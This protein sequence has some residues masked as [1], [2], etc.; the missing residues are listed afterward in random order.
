MATCRVEAISAIKRLQHALRLLHRRVRLGRNRGHLLA[1]RLEGA[2]VC[3]HLRRPRADPAVAEAA[4]PNGKSPNF[5]TVHQ[6]VQPVIHVSADARS[7]KI[8]VRLFQLGGPAGG[9]GSWISGIYENTAVDQGGT[10]KLSGTDLDYV[11][12]APSRGGWVR[13]KAPPTAPQLTM[14]TEFPP[15]RPLRA[16]SRHRS[17]KRCTRCRSTTGTRC[18]DASLRCCCRNCRPVGHVLQIREVKADPG[19]PAK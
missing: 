15:D 4:I 9:E 12:S 3:R 8:R 7:A 13:V 16:R 1:R 18:R 2:L 6:I 17:Q 14:A 19:F 5:L 10:W 11:W